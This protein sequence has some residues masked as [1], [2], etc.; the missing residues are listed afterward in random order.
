MNQSEEEELIVNIS[1]E[2]LK[3]M[4]KLI[5]N[6][7]LQSPQFNVTYVEVSY[8]VIK[9]EARKEIEL[10]IL[11][12]CVAG[13]TDPLGQLRDWFVST[14]NSIASWIV[15]GVTTFINTYLLPAV[16]GVIDSIISFIKNTLVPTLSGFISN[17]LDFLSSQVLPAIS[18]AI[19]TLSDLVTKTVLPAITGAISTI[20][21][22]ITKTVL[23]AISGFVNTILDTF[24]SISKAIIDTI[25]GVIKTIIDAISSIGK[26]ISDIV[27]GIGK[28]ILDALSGVARTIGDALASVGRAIS[29]FI[30]TI[31]NTISSIAKSI[32]D[33]IVSVGSSIANFI[34]TVVIPAIGNAFSSAITFIKD[35]IVPTIIGGLKTIGD[36]LVNAGQTIISGIINFINTYIKPSLDAIGGAVSKFFEMVIAGFTNVINIISAGFSELGRVTMGFINSILKFPEWFPKWFMDTIAKPIAEALGKIG[37][38]IWEAIPDW[39]K[40]AL[41]GIG[42]F[43]VEDLIK[44]F[45]ETLP[46]FVK[47]IS[48]EF[49]KFIKDP[50]GT[51]SKI[52]TDLVDNLWKGLQWIGEKLWG[53]IQWIW[54]TL[55]DTISS[56]IESVWNAIKGF[57]GWIINSLI[58]FF[59]AI[60][61]TL[62]SAI[63]G[64]LSLV[65]SAIIDAVK[66][67]VSTIIDLAKKGAEL[68]GKALSDLANW[69][70]KEIAKETITYHE[71]KLMLLI[72]KYEKGGTLIEDVA[73]F[74]T[75]ITEFMAAI[76][77]AHWLGY[78]VSSS[79]HALASFIAEQRV[80]PSVSAGGGGT[81]GVFAGILARIRAALGT[82]FSAFFHIKPEFL[83]REM[84][85]DARELSDTFTRGMIYGLSIWM[86][87]PL[88]RL[89]NSAF[90]DIL[91]I[92]LPPPTMME[93]IVRRYMPLG[94]F[95]EVRERYRGILRLY[96]Y[97]SDIIE[98][99]TNEEIHFTIIDRFDTERKINISLLYELPS[100]SETT[101][102]MIKDIFKDVDEFAYMLKSRGM[103]EDLAFLYY[104]L[105]FRYPPPER[106]WNFT[107]RGISGLLWATI[108]TEELNEVKTEASKLGAG[109]PVPPVALNFK[110]GELFKALRNY[111]KW[112]DYARFSWFKGFNFTSDNL[113]YIDTLADIPTKI[114]Q[115]WM[116]RFGI[117]ELLSQKG[118]LLTDP[119][120]AFRTKVIEP[121]AKSEVKLD[122]TNFC[123]TL[124]ATGLHPD[125]VPVTS[126]AETITAITDERTLL[127]TGT[128]N[129]FKEGFWNTESIETMLAGVVITSFQVAFFDSSKMEWGTGWINIPLMFLPPERKLTEL[130]AIMDRALD[131]LKEIQRDISIAY[132]ENI[133]IDYKEYKEKLEGVINNINTFFIIDFKKI[134]GQDIPEALKLRFVE[135]YYKPYVEAL[136]IYREVH[137][138]RRIRSWTMRWLGWLMYRIATGVTT[139]EEMKNLID[140]IN[141][142][143]KLTPTE[144]DFLNSVMNAMYTVALREYI[145]TPTQ[146]ATMSEYV[147]IPQELIKQVFDARLV[148]EN[149]RPIWFTYINIRPIADDVK[150][151]IN[152]YRRALLYVKVPPEIEKKVVEYAKLIGFTEREFD[153]LNL[154]NILEELIIVSRENKREYIPT[155]MTLAT[156]SEYL[157][158]VRALFPDIVKA[159]NIPEEW[160]KVWARYIDI[161]PLVDDIKKYL[162]RAESLYA[163]FMIK[164]EEFDKVLKEVSGYLGF[165]SKELEFLWKVTEYERYRKAWTELIGTVERLVSLSEY[166]PRATKYAL[167]KVKEMIDA[168]PLPDAD[169]NE[170]KA[171]WEEYIK[172]RPV[173]EEAKL[174]ITQL[175]NLFVEGL[176]TE[177]LFVKELEAMKEW[178][179]SDNEIMFYKAQ[180]GLRKARKL[181]IPIGE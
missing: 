18:G 68:F 66:G 145:P 169:K 174:Y 112:H 45:T 5:A 69:I 52:L 59:H 23:P 108:T 143:S 32:L 142:Y 78:G 107:A 92:E 95:K 84:A 40:N 43:F 140:I 35:V 17:I 90:R 14:L 147:V 106:L 176:I 167:G 163:G 150:A 177:D 76:V 137:T 39:L 73:S 146:L 118:V 168:L 102:M 42:K 13:L 88:A 110:Y 26:V 3:Q 151:L 49:D 74:L 33:A 82:T 158:E 104:F 91:A 80:N 155:P 126:V 178:G 70:F 58:S 135:E 179:F 51:I 180:A 29:G 71:Q 128:L 60:G 94:D 36:A 79:L 160:Q 148:P 153:I 11:S 81:G 136:N 37:E 63:I 162:N 9:E 19:S 93:E 21:D 55:V 156:M 164:R 75:Y 24:S 101:R 10:D 50:V 171:M 125:W 170:L 132:Q 166:S 124:Q 27:S 72:E 28:A 44:F 161:R 16:S 30:S 97:R 181:K 34:T 105:H 41:V 62:Y 53:G 46:D 149:W 61:K 64:G 96:G 87:S 141:K 114:D 144:V 31:A 127:R 100:L 6:A 120:S 2:E 119:V 20:S 133:I 4:S 173:K 121:T 85:K 47:T 48:E 172:N 123:R 98:F 83:L 122:L 77:G 129:L 22:L 8:V 57:F 152:A 165:T 1:P 56:I 109:I 99:L 117:Y 115:R 67:V 134:T 54:K 15:Q 38:W 89:A 86:W 138:T 103:K 159:R 175:I 116:T 65:G 131:I 25:S 139:I 154:R 111:M 130:R 157:P 113:L 12:S 7:L